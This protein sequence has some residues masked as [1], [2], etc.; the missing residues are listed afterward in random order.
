MVGEGQL[1]PLVSL[2]LQKPHTTR[3]K[4]QLAKALGL[5]LRKRS[6]LQNFDRGKPSCR[7][8]SPFKFVSRDF[9]VQESDAIR[10]SSVIVEL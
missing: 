10:A 9:T 4:E 8:D 5:H 3:P 7:S 2:Y 6:Y 1:S